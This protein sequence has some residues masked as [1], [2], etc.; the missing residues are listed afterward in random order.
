LGFDYINS[1][2]SA[3]KQE[4]REGDTANRWGFHYLWNEKQ[5]QEQFEDL[6]NKSVRVL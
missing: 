6:K 5:K 2:F 4:L 1:R 3:L